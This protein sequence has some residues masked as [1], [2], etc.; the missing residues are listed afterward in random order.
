MVLV[1]EAQEP[2]SAEGRAVAA[3]WNHVHSI[4]ARLAG[5]RFA[6]L[7][8]RPPAVPVGNE[9]GPAA[10]AW[11]VQR[12]ADYEQQFV[13]LDYAR[14][15]ALVPALD[16]REVL[17]AEPEVPDAVLKRIG[18][19]REISNAQATGFWF[20]RGKR[21]P[22]EEPSYFPSMAVLAAAGRTLTEGPCVFA[23]AVDWVWYPLSE[24]AIYTYSH[25]SEL[26]DG[27]D[28]IFIRKG[29]RWP[30]SERSS[31]DTVFRVTH[32]GFVEARDVARE[33]GTDVAQRAR[34]GARLL[35]VSLSPSDARPE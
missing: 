16:V 33:Y 27:R 9:G 25:A 30:E 17:L 18:F 26:V 35:L 29:A 11:L 12:G 24:H 22:A 5:L 14:F 6:V 2:T 23:V 8:K 4:P 7:L 34:S 20:D 31:P 15:A 1:A 28:G 13:R 32:A 21:I 3:V 19:S 10:L